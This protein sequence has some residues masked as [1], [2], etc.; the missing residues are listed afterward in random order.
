MSETP[1]SQ[2]FSHFLNET[3][4]YL[5]TLAVETEVMQNKTKPFSNVEIKAVFQDKES[6]QAKK[7]QQ[8]SKKESIPEKEYAD[9]VIDNTILETNGKSTIVYSTLRKKVRALLPGINSQRLTDRLNHLKTE[10]LL[11]EATA[12]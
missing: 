9:D 10:G 4:G 12:E 3:C 1:F 8:L 7:E 6:Q 5:Q 2:I 11:V